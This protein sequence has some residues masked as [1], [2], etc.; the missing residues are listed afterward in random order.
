[1]VRNY[2]PISIERLSPWGIPDGDRE[3]E[4]QVVDEQE[5]R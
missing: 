4:H 2:S 3:A 5:E 1:M